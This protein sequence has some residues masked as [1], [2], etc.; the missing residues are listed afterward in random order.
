MLPSLS[1]HAESLKTICFLFCF[2][3]DFSKVNYLFVTESANKEIVNRVHF[4]SHNSKL[5]K[6][7]SLRNGAVITLKNNKIINLEIFLYRNCK[8]LGTFST[9]NFYIKKVPQQFIWRNI[10]RLVHILILLESFLRK[11]YFAMTIHILTLSI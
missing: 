4:H 6:L 5:L 3:F 9:W 8:F 10:K 2:I 7:W 11:K 1:L